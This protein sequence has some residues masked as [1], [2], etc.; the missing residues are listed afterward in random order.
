[1][2]L[3]A[4]QNSGKVRHTE[5]KGNVADLPSLTKVINCER[6]ERQ[7]EG[8][9][10]ADAFFPPMHRLC[11]F[12]R[13][14]VASVKD[15]YYN[16]GPAAAKNKRYSCREELAGCTICLVMTVNCLYENSRAIYALQ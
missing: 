3:S 6:A 15:I 8:E 13:K 1:M 10:R 12:A 4:Y 9:I 2:E 11:L 14:K 7:W 5:Q 16:G